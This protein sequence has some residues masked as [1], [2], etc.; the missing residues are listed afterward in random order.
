MSEQQRK[1][2]LLDEVSDGYTAF[3][4]FLSRLSPQHMLVP[5]VNGAW[6]IKDC[7]TH[8]TAWHERLLE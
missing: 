1:T 7:I 5:N 2:A 8:L 3:E 4:T 6:S